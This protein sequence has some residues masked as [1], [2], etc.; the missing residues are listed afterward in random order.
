MPGPPQ[1]PFCLDLKH[2]QEQCPVVPDAELRSK[3]RKAREANYRKLRIRHVLCLGSSFNR[4]PPTNWQARVQ[5]PARVNVVEE[6]PAYRTDELC[7]A[8]AEEPS[9]DLLLT[10]EAGEDA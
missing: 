1:C 4:Q 2:R 6:V 9:E 5:P 3:L 8:G 7:D 10:G